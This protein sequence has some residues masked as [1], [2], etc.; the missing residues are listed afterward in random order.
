MNNQAYKRLNHEKQEKRQQKRER[1]FSE[2][3]KF[4]KMREKAYQNDETEK[5][6]SQNT[7]ISDE[8]HA[9]IHKNSSKRKLKLLLTFFLILVLGAT[10]FSKQQALTHSSNSP[11][12]ASSQS[13]EL[14]G[15]TQ[16]RAKKLTGRFIHIT[17][18]H[19]DPHYVEGSSIE[20][21]CH[22]KES[23]SSALDEGEEEVYKKKKKTPKKQTKAHK[24]GDAMQGC[25]SSMELMQESMKWI[26]QEFPASEIDFIVWTGD[27]IRHD[28]D[29]R[30]PR[31]QTEIVEMNKNMSDMFHELW[32][33]PETEGPFL[34]ETIPIIPSLG[35]N[36]VFPHNVVD[37]GPGQFMRTFNNIWASFIPEEQQRSFDRFMSF[38]QEI[39]PGKLAVL[40]INTLH[41]YKS[42]PLVDNCNDKDQAGYQMLIWFGLLMQEFRDRGMKVWI[43]GHVPPI[44]KNFESS[45]YQKFNLW[46]WEY[47]DLIVG[48]L[49]GHMNMDHFVPINGRDLGERLRGANLENMDLDLQSRQDTVGNTDMS[50]DAFSINNEVTIFG[51]KPVNKMKYIKTLKQQYKHVSKL[52]NKQNSDTFDPADYLVIN[53]AGSVIPTFNPAFRVWEYNITGLY[54][55]DEDAQ[56]YDQ[57]NEYLPWAEFFTQVDEQIDTIVHEDYENFGK[58]TLFTKLKESI[59]KKGKKKNKKNKKK[60]KKQKKDKSIPPKMPKDAALGPAYKPQLFSPVS[61][62]QYYLDLPRFNKNLKQSPKDTVF[63]YDLEYTFN[64]TQMESLLV[65]GYLKYCKSLIKDKQLWKKYLKWLFVS[66]DYENLEDN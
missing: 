38:F 45:C 23:S 65:D 18:I 37:I 28:N 43:T 35:N 22:R 30:I 64:N 48:G 56:E 61:F 44:E 60:K 47:R 41:F 4:F 10:Y 62:K 13:S 2:P 25:D 20:S 26:S 58:D 39:I 5:Y 34:P 50:S 3:F 6:V 36:D 40:S 1:V 53:V 31:T 63:E 55:N 51:A 7:N 14:D 49:Y 21:S 57:L 8:F 11:A 9:D 59:M 29:R 32:A 46:C 15:K 19:P 33:V 66:T 16:R 54:D 12:V 17:D 24:F 52:Q 27:N 42:N